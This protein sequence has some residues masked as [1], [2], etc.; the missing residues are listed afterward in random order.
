MA[1]Q[2]KRKRTEEDSNSKISIKSK[3][4]IT[5]TFCVLRK[6][7]V[8]HQVAIQH[9]ARAIRCR[10][11]DVGLAGIKDMQA[12]TYQ[13]CTLRI[14]LQRAKHANHALNGKRV[15]LSHF[16]AV[17][18]YLLNRG[19]LS[20]NSFEI[21]VRN[22]TRVE[23][24]PV[25]EDGI[26][27]NHSNDGQINMVWKER[28]IPCHSSHLDG[29]VQR[30]RNS[31]FINFYGEQRV[32]DAGSSDQVGVRSFDVG[33]AMLQKKFS[34]AIDLIMIG[35]SNLLYSPGDEEIQARKV[36][37]SYQSKENENSL[38]DRARATLKVFPKNTTTMV[39]ERDLLKGLVRYDD[40]LEAIRCVPHNVRMFW[41]HGYQSYVWNM[42]ASERI[43]RWGVRPM[44]GDL[45]MA[46]EDGC[47]DTTRD[48]LVVDN[49]DNVDI[50]QIVLPVSRLDISS[51][52]MTIH[53]MRLIL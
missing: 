2:K 38:Q 23:R 44:V 51:L 32:G 34:H 17:H 42:I 29:M 15:E 12:V 50:H 41:I 9:I 19:D 13:F 28:E 18:D 11:Q 16:E 20:G 33:R 37:T 14:D 31:G 30:V 48:L 46:D 25:M 5:A 39:R 21:V 3:A 40:P 35:R 53:S 52:E 45:Y 8:E 1:S 27:S 43:R 10:P 7:Q 49:P 36:W 26:P 4:S 22:L 24:M 47:E 6:E